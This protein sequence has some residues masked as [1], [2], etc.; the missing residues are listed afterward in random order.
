M[1]RGYASLGDGGA[2]QAFLHTL[3]AVIDPLGQRVSATDR[4]YL[5]AM[6]PTLILWGRRDPL[7]PVDHAESAHGRC[8][9]A[10]R[11]FEKSGHFP[12]ST[13][14]CGSRGR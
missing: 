9:A 4:L 3:R 7:I 14:P 6:V 5:A 1:A 2:R 13:S 12:T 8:P 10:A 11:V